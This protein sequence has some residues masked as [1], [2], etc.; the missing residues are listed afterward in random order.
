MVSDA[1]KIPELY[2]RYAHAWATDRG[3]R[4]FETPWLDRCLG[5]VPRDGAIVDIG[6][7]SAQPIARYFIEK[8]YDVTGV[9]SSPALI[10]ICKSH[11]P[12]HKWIVS[13]MRTL[14]LS[15]LFSGILAWDSFFHLCPEDQRQMFPI[16]RKHAAPDAALMFTSGPSPPEAIGRF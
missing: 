10:D 7:G 4:L 2:Q 3:N 8:G 13:D 9:D 16:F 14:S 11:F 15:R 1:E 5:L 12:G 6:C